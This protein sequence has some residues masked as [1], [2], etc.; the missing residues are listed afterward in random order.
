[1]TMTAQNSS[2]PFFSFYP[3]I[4]VC[5]I[6]QLFEQTLRQSLQN[7]HGLKARA[8]GLLLHSHTVSAQGLEQ[9]FSFIQFQELD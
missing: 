1:M 4:H 8:Q 5:G 3:S 7:A 6:Q 9:C 2:V